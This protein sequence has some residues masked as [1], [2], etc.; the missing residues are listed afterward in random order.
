MQEADSIT[1]NGDS[2]PQ[3]IRSFPRRLRAIVELIDG[4]LKIYPIGQS[5][6]ECNEILQALLLDGGREPGQ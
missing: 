2:T 6:A 4:E 1:S 5:D 3:P